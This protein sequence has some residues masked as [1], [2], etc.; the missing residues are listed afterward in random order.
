MAFLLGK[1]NV[2]AYSVN[3]MIVDRLPG[4]LIISA[5]KTIFS[6]AGGGGG[7]G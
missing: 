1:K 5:V 7:T 2:N 4:S 3:K 6:T